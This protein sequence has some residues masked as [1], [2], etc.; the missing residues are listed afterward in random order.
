MPREQNWPISIEFQLLAGLDDGKA[1][2]TG[3]MCSPG[4]R[5][6]L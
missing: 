4:Y 3:N 5:C 1:R 2:P 6:G